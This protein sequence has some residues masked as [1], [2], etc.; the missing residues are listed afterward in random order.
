[1]QWGCVCTGIDLCIGVTCKAIDEC[2]DAGECYH[3]TCSTPAK[4]DGASCDDGDDGTVLD[5]CVMGKCKGE[6]PCGGKECPSSRPCGKGYCD[7]KQ[8]KCMEMDLP[9]ET[10]CDDGQDKTIG[11]RCLSGKCVGTD[12]CANVTCVAVN[13][14]Q[15]PGQCNHLTGLCSTSP[16]PDGTPCD[17][18]QNNTVEDSC[19]NGACVGVDKCLGKACAPRNNCYLKGRCDINTGNCI[20]TKKADKTPCDDGNNRTVHDMCFDG[21]CRGEDKC[22]GVVCSAVSECHEAGT[23]DPFTGMCSTPPAADGKQCDDGVVSTVNDTCLN[24]TCTGKDLCK[25]KQCTG[26]DVC[27]EVP[28]CDYLTGECLPPVPKKNGTQCDDGLPNTVQDACQDG[29]CKGVNLCKDVVCIPKVPCETGSC[30]TMTGKCVFE[31]LPDDTECNDGDARTGDDMCKGGKCV[32]RDLCANYT[33]TAK[34]QC[35]K[36]GV[37]DPSRAD[38]ERNDTLCTSPIKEDGTVCDDNDA[39][40][41]GDVCRAGKCIGVSCKITVVKRRSK[42]TCTF[43]KKGGR[44]LDGGFGFTPEGHMYVDAGCRADFRIEATSQEIRCESWGF[45]YKECRLSPRATLCAPAVP[46]PD[47]EWLKIGRGYCLDKSQQRLSYVTQ[48]SVMTPQGCMKLA[49]GS[50]NI[51]GVE[52]NSKDHSC[53]L[54]HVPGAVPVGSW[55]SKKDLPGIAPVDTSDGSADVECYVPADRCIGVTCVAIDDCHDI[56]VCNNASGTCTTPAKPDGSLCDDGD[57]TTKVDICKQGNCTGTTPPGC[58]RASRRVPS[59]ECAHDDSA[60][61][62]SEVWGTMEECCRPGNAHPNGCAPAPEKPKECW[63]ASKYFPN[64]ECAVNKEAC[65]WTWGTSVWGS[66]AE[67]CRP[68][69]AH[70]CGCSDLP[71]NC[72]KATGTMTKRECEHVPTECG[73]GENEGV[74]TSRERCCKKTYGE[75][76]CHLPCR[77]L[78]VV[79]VVDGSGSMKA[80]FGRHPHGYNAIMDML[81]DWVGEQLPLTGEKAGDKSQ[82]RP[83]QGGVRVGIIQFSAQ[84]SSYGRLISAAK[85]VPSWVGTG[86]RLS[87]DANEL[88]TDLKWHRQYFYNSGTY[89]QKAF[90]LAISMFQK[91][92]DER[93]RVLILL[94]DG[95]IF[96]ANTLPAL[97]RQLDDQKVIVFGVVVRRQTSH[98]QTDLEAE[99]TLKP[100]LSRPE[101]DHFYN[102]PIDEV[103]DKVLKGI[104]DEKGKWGCYLVPQAVPEKPSTGTGRCTLKIPSCAH[105]ATQTARRCRRVQSVGATP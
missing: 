32:G 66:K 99:R 10:G 81:Y 39:E 75:Y 70:K 8:N 101:E 86:G 84:R 28:K 71:K 58:Y 56:G 25:G 68:G 45:N 21:E 64:R 3:G 47:G 9:D 95:K 48:G 6:P 11:D 57:D 20:E 61:G 105:S 16:K 2:H 60:C 27:N 17:D 33:C 103:P 49:E 29:V 78:D 91:G 59:Q 54:L 37:C 93:Q 5:K 46:E 79:F 74:F 19:K 53:S 80:S 88:R 30:D 100:I 62:S 85:T 69:A 50:V 82:A 73:K 7:K 31:H 14:C 23:C 26:G 94:T 41:V 96:D 63:A 4:A 51:V 22:K 18:G 65:D 42:S 15:T 72:F 38:V 52:Y 76:G 98:T 34:S 102:L 1:M 83:P 24:G 67:C 13:P 87:G 90:S 89:I 40:T 12:L 92:S 55:A 44:R 104:C 77:T 36:V 43:G 35:H 97:R